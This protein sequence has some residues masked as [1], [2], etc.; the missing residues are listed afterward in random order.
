MYYII[1]INTFILFQIYQIKI[2]TKYF[3]W[4]KINSKNKK[5]D[6][7]RQI[8]IH[9][10]FIIFNYSNLNY[11]LIFKIEEK[12]LSINDLYLNN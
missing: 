7:L 4:K 10:N 5:N 9:E 8:L 2:Y 11:L 6:V 3:G 12:K 1:E